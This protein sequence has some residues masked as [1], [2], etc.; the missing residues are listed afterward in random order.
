MYDV[1]VSTAQ[2][3]LC[4]QWNLTGGVGG[5]IM[6]HNEESESRCACVINGSLDHILPKV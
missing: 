6:I 4:K 5:A 2:H 3:W 1:A